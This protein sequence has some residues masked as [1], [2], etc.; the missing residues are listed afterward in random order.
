VDPE[1][2]HTYNLKLDPPSAEGKAERAENARN[3][4]LPS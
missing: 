1:I 4:A 2:S 3:I